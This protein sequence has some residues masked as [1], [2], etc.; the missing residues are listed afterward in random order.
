MAVLNF[1]FGGI[2]LLIGLLAVLGLSAGSELTHGAII[3]H[4][5]QAWIGA[6]ALVLGGVLLLTSGI[7]YLKQA[8]GMGR[9]LANV[10]AVVSLAST[11]YGIVSPGGAFGIFTI[12][13][14][15][16]PVLTLFLVNTTFK[17]DLVN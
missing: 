10:Y 12:V 1:V 5:M 17:D 9:M 14:L 7:G 16:Y 6:G 2:A 8:R 11:V 13:L 3:P 4:R 15:I